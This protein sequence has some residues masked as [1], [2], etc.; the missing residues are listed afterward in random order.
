M[1]SNRPYLIRS[2]YQWIV[3][4]RLTPYVLVDVKKG[5]V[6]VPYQYVENGRIVLN[7]S[8]AAVRDLNLSNE[9]V[10]FVARFNGQAMNVYIPSNAVLAIY[11]RENGHGMVF[12][13]LQSLGDPVAEPLAD[14]H[15]N[16]PQS[17]R[18]H[19]HLKIVK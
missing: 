8:P 3:D 1:T 2:I 9:A 13:E 12:N 16:P 14:D 17:K 15:A 6:S 7:V 11:A 10:E 19:P 4:N 18:E 5:N